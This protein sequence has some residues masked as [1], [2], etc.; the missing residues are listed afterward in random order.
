MK[1]SA[2]LCACVLVAAAMLGVANEAMKPEPVQKLDITPRE[3][4]SEDTRSVPSVS[5]DHAKVEAAPFIG[6]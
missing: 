2:L 1:K 4:Q 6:Q 3:I 5:G